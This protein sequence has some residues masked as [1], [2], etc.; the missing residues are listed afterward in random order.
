MEEGQP[1][2]TIAIGQYGRE[3][4]LEVQ[5]RPESLHRPRSAF[6]YSEFVLADPT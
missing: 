6:L 3:T 4:N 1:A 2:M 5:Y